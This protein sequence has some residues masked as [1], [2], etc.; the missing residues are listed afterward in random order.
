[1]SAP[2]IP[3]GDLRER[4]IAAVRD[5][6]KP[7]TFHSL[8]KSTKAKPESLRAALESA[9]DRGQLHRWPNRGKS[10][11]FWNVAPEQKAREAILA[12]AAAQALSKSKLSKLAAKMLPGYAVKNM[13]SLVS[14][15]V[16]DKQLQEAPAF[17][18]TSKLLVQPGDHKAYLRAA[19]FGENLP[20]RDPLP[21][22]ARPLII[23]AVRLLEPVKGVP[24]STL[25]LRNHLPNLTK[26]E[27]DTAALELRKRQHVFLSQH[28][29]PHN[30]SQEDRNSLIDGQDGTYYLAIAIR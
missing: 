8:A 11:Y 30:L 19:G 2:A 13:E 27:F 25:R 12:T 29:D 21:V 20:P 1:M 15:L 26:H 22:D 18:R 24:V 17:A 5:A 23:E 10:Q 9:V 4:V 16:A 7:V 14:V 28:A 6:E 3:Q